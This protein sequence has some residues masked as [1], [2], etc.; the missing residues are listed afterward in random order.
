MDKLIGLYQAHQAEA[1]AILASYTRSSCASN[2]AAVSGP[3]QPG[4][5]WLSTTSGLTPAT[6]CRSLANRQAKV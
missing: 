4:N 1:S 3:G 5:R 2:A 6:A